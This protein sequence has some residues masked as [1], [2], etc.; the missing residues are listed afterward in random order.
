MALS[1]ETGPA[2]VESDGRVRRGLALAIPILLTLIV[3]S[4][5]FAA[6]VETALH[7]SGVAIDGPFQLYNAL[8]RIDG[9]FR[10]GVG[11]QFFHGIGIP[12]LH[13]PFYR[14][15]GGTFAASELARQLIA[16][17]AYPLVFLALFRAFT[18]D[19]RRSLTRR[20]ALSS[21]ERNEFERGLYLVAFLRGRPRR[22][23]CDRTAK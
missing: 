14:L 9:G 12:F 1:T 18:G 4:I 19:W 17:F 10:P 7:F 6:A 8:R 3:F 13:Y 22:E 23:V 15:F 21:S 20:P 16:C 2:G 5:P 11:F